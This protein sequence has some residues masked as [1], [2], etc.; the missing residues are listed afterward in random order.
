M[1]DF[2]IDHI[3]QGSGFFSH[4]QRDTKKPPTSDPQHGL[5]RANDDLGTLGLLCA[6]K[7]TGDKRYLSA[8][9]KFMNA[10]FTDQQEDGGFEDSVACIPVVINTIF[11]A[12]DKIE[13]AAMQPQ[14][15]ESALARLFASQSDGSSIPRM[16][17]G[18]VEISE[19][20]VC[21]RSG[22]YA[23]IMLLKLFGN[24]KDYLC[25]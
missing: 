6:H 10:V 25:V 2:F 20:V 19:G 8:I 15:I 21:S 12:S 7:I 9:E 23:L 13:V 1:A 5:H 4:I 18:L 14:A 24:S 3:Q 16:R 11:E 17:G 22:S